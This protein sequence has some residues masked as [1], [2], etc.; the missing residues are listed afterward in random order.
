MFCIGSTSRIGRESWY[1][2]FFLIFSKII[3]FKQFKESFFHKKNTSKMFKCN[4]NV[5]RPLEV[6]WPKQKSKLRKSCLLKSG[7]RYLIGWIIKAS[8]SAKDCGRFQVFGIFLLCFLSVFRGL[9]SEFS[10][11]VWDY[12]IKTVFFLKIY[13]CFGILAQKCVETCGNCV[14]K[15]QCFTWFQT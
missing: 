11:R 13:F 9:F 15:V 12:I 2:G 3:L 7:L 10:S 14:L 6:L 1:A 8:E 5:S 4:F